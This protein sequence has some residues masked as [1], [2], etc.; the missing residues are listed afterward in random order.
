MN[1]V[2]NLRLARKRAKRRQNEQTAAAN[3]LVFGRT[4]TERTQVRSSNDKATRSLDQRRI[5]T[6]D[7]Q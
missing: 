1:D 6:G 3:R 7:R 2:V 4:K 5:E